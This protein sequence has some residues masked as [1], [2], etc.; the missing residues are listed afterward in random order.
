MTSAAE[1]AMA[2]LRQPGQAIPDAMA[3]TPDVPGLYSVHA[4]PEGLAQLGLASHKSGAPIYVGLASKSLRKRDT[5]QHFASS[6]TGG[7]TVRRSCAA[8]LVDDLHL[9]PTPRGTKSPRSKWRLA[10]KSQEASLTE[11]M[12]EHLTLAVWPSPT[13]IDLETTETALIRAWRPPLNL[14]KNPAKWVHLQKH[15]DTMAELAQPTR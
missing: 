1:A 13:G 6:A 3:N 5:R 11:W 2:A 14:S 7:S 8:L 10:T 4:S 12:Q 15:R 9:T